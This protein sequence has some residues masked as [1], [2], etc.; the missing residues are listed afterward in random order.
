METRMTERDCICQPTDHKERNEHSASCNRAFRTKQANKSKPPKT[1]KPINK[2]SYKMSE[3]LKT[4]AILRRDF[5][6][7]NPVCEVFKD[8]PATEVHHQRGR[9]TI[10]LLLDTNYWLA[11]S[12][13]AHQKI[14]LNP[15]WAKEQGY[16]LSRLSKQTP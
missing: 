10:E 7:S 4:Y 2:T 5:L 8:R 3:A 16:S 1:K 11:V 12:R 9:N 15:E 6:K 13:E 14:E